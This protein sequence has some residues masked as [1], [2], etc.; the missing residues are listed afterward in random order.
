MAA[1][2]QREPGAAVEAYTRLNAPGDLDPNHIDGIGPIWLVSHLS[3]SDYGAPGRLDLND[4]Q[5]EVTIRTKDFEANGAQLAFWVIR[6]LPRE[7]VVANYYV[8]LQSTNWAYTGGNF[9]DQLGEEW[10]TITVDIT[11]NMDDWTYAGNY[12]SA[13]GD[14][15]D[16]YV[17]YDLNDT[18]TNLDA[19]VHL[20]LIGESPDQ[21]PTGFIDLASIRIRTNTEAVPINR[22]E[23]AV[24]VQTDED[25]TAQGQLAVPAGI[26]GDS[27]TF[28]VV[29]GSALNGTVSVNATSGAFQFTPDEDFW[30]P[31]RNSEKAT[32]RY[33]VSD[34]MTTSAAQTVLVK[35]A[36]INDAPELF[37]GNEDVTIA[38]DVPFSYR[39][40]PGE[41]PD[42]SE[43]LTFAVVEGS[44][45]NG[46]LSLDQDTG[47]YVFTP[48]IGF[49]GTAEF[50]YVLSDGQITTAAKT[51]RLSVT[52]N[53]TEPARLSFEEAVNTYL[54]PGDI[55]SFVYWTML[56]AEEG[57]V[58]ASYHYGTW[59]A[60]ARYVNRDTA[61]A[62]EML[63]VAH[64]TVADATLVLAQ[65][66]VAGDGVDRNY[67]EAR[68]LLESLGDDPTALY[69][70]GTL[71]DLG[72][73]G[74]V[75][76]ISAVNRYIE[77]AKAGSADAMYTLGRRYLDGQGAEYQPD[78]AY[79]WLGVGLRLG[80]GPPIAQFDDLLR[81]NMNLVRSELTADRIAELD[82][83][84]A[85][86]TPGDAT[87]VNDAP[88]PAA[89]AEVFRAFAG[90]TITGA[91]LAATDADRDDVVFQLVDGSAVGGSATI[92]PVTGSFEFTP[93]QGFTGN[94]TFSYRVSDG[95]GVSASKTVTLTLAAAA[96]AE[97]DA[98]DVAETGEIVVSADAGILS[99]DLYRPGS[100]THVQ[101]AAAVFGAPITGAYGTLTM[102]SDGAYSYR[103][104]A[105]QLTQ[106]QTVTDTF[107]Y[108]IRDSG[109]TVDQASLIITISGSGGVEMTGSGM[110]L[111]SDYGDHLIG[112][113]DRDVIIGR[114]GNDRIDAGPGAAN[115]L[116]GQEGND[117]YYVRSAGD[118]IIELADQ[119]VDAVVTWLG[120]MTLA[121]H[122]ENLFYFGATGFAG[123][124]NAQ[125]NYIQG[126]AM[127]DTLSGL[128]GND[129]LLGEDGDDYLFGGDGNDRL[130]GG[131][132][133][134]RLYGGDGLD[135][136][137]YETST[138][139]VFIQL[140]GSGLVQNGSGGTDQ[141]VGIENLR[142]S[143]YR[144]VL[145][146]SNENNVLTGLGGN[147]VLIGLGGADRLI[148]EQTSSKTLQGGTGNDVYVVHH[149]TDT[150]VEFADEGT[151]TVETYSDVF[152][153]KSN[154]ENLANM[155]SSGFVGLGNALDNTLAGSDG[156]DYLIGYE[157]NDT[158]V[159]GAGSANTLIG[160]AGD[161]LYRVSSRGD[162]TVEAL[163][164]GF[165]TVETTLSD[166][167][168]RDNFEALTFVG[169]GGFSGTGNAG[170]NRL[171][172]GAWN[173]TLTGLGGADTFV[174]ARNFGAD[175]IMDFDVDTVGETVDLTALPEIVDFAD[176]VGNHLVANASGY[177]LIFCGSGT[178]ELV[179]VST[180][181]LLPGHFDFAP[182]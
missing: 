100:I 148:G 98:A 40:R 127:D 174:F 116:Y 123:I 31:E 17:H 126:H 38:G 103:A 67:T 172:G 156:A 164:E 86:W 66:Y 79:F 81:H 42:R 146:G 72:F 140:N 43:T 110:L 102:D 163:G 80:G 13:Q 101:G 134:N 157:G 74:P 105:G 11:N 170:A 77:A 117:T 75:D 37:A 171:S 89:A 56:L 23:Y 169:T 179:G 139:G 33:T 57:D 5:I 93:L 95:Q 109:G 106:G 177:A 34:G 82:A 6:Y 24:V 138:V 129:T 149:R 50:S 76:H 45:R 36:P 1:S 130:V 9:I 87:P 136:A 73:G 122:V 112:G 152:R 150:I 92:D 113:T 141:L 41:D 47:A 94:A 144:D 90:Q 10:A 104:S 142:G 64:G 155:S 62:A 18:L 160:G 166:F 182:V 2:V 44:V 8:G 20:V 128:D 176:L 59:L 143:A 68:R 131:S 108:A 28:Q 29:A 161:D 30:G 119:G 153:L 21:R 159:G 60:A 85:G 125:A 88:V 135:T 26:D 132:G 46:T 25:A 32:F 12:T 63:N 158:L 165:D 27:A 178:I 151:D 49:D 154:L 180:S 39:L 118:T 22:T 97:D 70:L 53:G 115:E 145:I 16:R 15:A 4:S 137:S 121:P 114:G 91:L 96:V 51:V 99:N 147:D 3:L 107:T 52:P 7:D 162:T 55:D 175:R 181:Q 133:T 83:A 173:D 61:T 168:L 111:G 167:T 120:A 124:G 48:T 19:T 54:I 14:W 65:L 58:N 71:D 84:I 78:D 69:R 35:V